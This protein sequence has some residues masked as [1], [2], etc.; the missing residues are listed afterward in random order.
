MWFSISPTLLILP[1]CGND[2]IRTKL[3]EVHKNPFYIC[4][5]IDWLWFGNICRGKDDLLYY[6]VLSP[7]TVRRMRTK[8]GISVSVWKWWRWCWWLC[9]S[10]IMM[11]TVYLLTCALVSGCLGMIMTMGTP[12]K[13]LWRLW[14]WLFAHLPS[15]ANINSNNFWHKN[16]FCWKLWKIKRK[17][18]FL[19]TERSTSPPLE[20]IILGP[21]WS[22]VART[23]LFIICPLSQIFAHL[24]PQ[25]FISNANT[26]RPPLHFHRS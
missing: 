22:I 15:S 17:S 3:G 1:P 11:A 6:F 25:C 9:L 10:M 26:K 19:A 18:D 21:S 2:L 13:A 14:L 5:L 12:I 4:K 7:Y 23:C 16:I 20:N 24:S 8:G